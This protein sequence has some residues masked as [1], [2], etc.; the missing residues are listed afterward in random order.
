MNEVLVPDN[1][2]CES[3][4][5]ITGALSP[6]LGGVPCEGA[7]VGRK[8]LNQAAPRG[9]GARALAAKARVT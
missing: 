3:L 1:A 4:R 5:C 8:G 7:I 2:R 6:R 9:R